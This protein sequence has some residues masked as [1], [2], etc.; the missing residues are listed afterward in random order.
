MTTSGKNINAIAIHP[1]LAKVTNRITERSQTLRSQYLARL[2]QMR[3][4]G[5]RHVV[6]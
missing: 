4:R 3:H 1:I 5:P 2:E 6:G